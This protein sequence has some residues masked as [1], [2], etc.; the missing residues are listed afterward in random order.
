MVGQQQPE[1]VW[2]P[3]SAPPSFSQEEGT[4]GPEEIPASPV[5]GGPRRASEQE[6]PAARPPSCSRNTG[7][8]KWSWLCRA[9]PALPELCCWSG[10]LPFAPGP[11]QAGHL[12]PCLSRN[13]KAAAT[14]RVSPQ[15]RL[16]PWKA[17]AGGALGARAESG[18]P[19][20]HTVVF[21]EHLGC[22]SPWQGQQSLLPAPGPLQPWWVGEWL[23]WV[24]ADGDG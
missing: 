23:P 2:S 18:F 11:G 8:R 7:S 22:A 10:G 17:W 19:R 16:P 15:R 3:E 14:C 12:R 6:M 13:E 9:P 5:S 1:L 24:E 4:R 21:I 20:W